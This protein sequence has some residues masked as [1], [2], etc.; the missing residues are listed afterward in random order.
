MYLLPYPSRVGADALIT[1]CLLSLIS[2]SPLPSPPLLPSTLLSL[3]PTTI[4]IYIIPKEF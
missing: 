3:T 1:R 2:S 4:M